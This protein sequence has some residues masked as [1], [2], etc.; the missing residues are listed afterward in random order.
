M[1]RNRNQETWRQDTSLDT[2]T[3][4]DNIRSDL[5]NVGLKGVKWIIC[6]VKLPVLP[7]LGEILEQLSNC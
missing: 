1:H 4:E 5:K 7:E 2:W 3:Q 6:L